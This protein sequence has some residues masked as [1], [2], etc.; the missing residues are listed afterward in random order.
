MTPTSPGRTG[1][2]ASPRGSAV[3][4]VSRSGWQLCAHPRRSPAPLNFP[5]AVI[6]PGI[7]GP[8][9]NAKADGRPPTISS[10]S[11]GIRRF[12]EADIA[13]G[14]SSLLEILLTGGARTDANVIAAN[15]R[16]QIR[17]CARL[18]QIFMVYVPATMFLAATVSFFAHSYFGFL[19]FLAVPVS[20]LA[21]FAIA[22]FGVARLR[23]WHCGD[24]LLSVAYP[25]WP[26]Q[27]I[28]THCCTAINEPE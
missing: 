3:A 2:Q 16:A 18:S 25:A 15:R 7:D 1:Q 10:H 26:F 21:G 27:N 12:S 4:E 5:E 23:C 22:A 9:G 28:C 20:L 13:H 19:F 17:R 24:R 8:S 6:R 14:S 11:T